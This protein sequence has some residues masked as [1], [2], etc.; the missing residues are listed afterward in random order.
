MAKSEVDK[1]YGEPLRFD[2][3]F[4]GPLEKRSCTDVIC[5]LL[6]IAFLGCWGFVGYFAYQHGELDRIL[7]PSDSNGLRCGVDSEVLDKPHLVFFD[8]AKCADPRVPLTG[9]NTPQVCVSNCPN[10]T[11]IFNLNDCQRGGAA[12]FGQIRN[13][14]ICDIKV[15]KERDIRSC[16]DIN[17]LVEASRCA[18][19]YLRGESSSKHCLPSDLNDIQ[20]VISSSDLYKALQNL[21]LLYGVGQMVVED[22]I[23]TWP[24]MVASLALAAVMCLIFIAMMRWIAGPFIWISIFGVV[25]LLGGGCYFCYVQYMFLKDNPVERPPPSTNISAFFEQYLILSETWLYF[26]IGLSIVTVVIVLVLILLRKRIVIAIALIKE[27]SKAVSAI[28]STYFFPIFPW[29]M[30]VAVIGIAIVVGLHLAS[31]GEQVFKVGGMNTTTSC[32]CAVPYVDGEVCVPEQFNQYCHKRG[33][34]EPCSDAACHFISIEN[35]VLVKYFHGVNILGLFWTVFFISAFEEMV[36]AATFATWY[37]TFK[38]SQLPFFTLTRGITRTMRYHLGTLAFGSLII[39]VC[40][41]IRIVLEYIDNKCKKYNNEITRAILCMFRCLFW[42]L[43]KFL[44]FLNKN[45]YIMCAIHGKSFCGSAKDA[46]NLLMRNFLRVLALDKV[47]DF[48]FFLSK[49]LIALGMGACMYTFL[50]SN[51]SHHDLHYIQVPIVIVICGTYLI[52][53]VF[54]SVYSMAVD[55]LFLCFLEDSE[56][57]DGTPEKPYFMSKQLKRILGKHNNFNDTSTP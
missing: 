21:R 28:T 11:F 50:I 44:R 20:L 18:R 31:I 54:F 56:R 23:E 45:A 14:L 1:T 33:T 57:N 15:N 25:G 13:K 35:P 36:L 6:F 3:R 9:C 37:W 34:N 32:E 53:C 49:L 51:Y 17:R 2:P 29:I 48:L 42:L 26:L 30:Q 55:T 19:W 4:K 39:A 41:I 38:K 43:E 27:G 52:A 47:A 5:L 40:R 8:L 12:T 22:I 46:F 7:V 10:E 16:D 24:T